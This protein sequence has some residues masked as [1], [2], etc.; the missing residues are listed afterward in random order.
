MQSLLLATI[1]DYEQAINSP[2]AS[3]FKFPSLNDFCTREL[4]DLISKLHQKLSEKVIEG[5]C[6]VSFSIQTKQIGFEMWYF[7]SAIILDRNFVQET[8]LV[9]V[10]NFTR[11]T[12][13]LILKITTEIFPS[14]PR[15]TFVSI[16]EPKTLNTVM[17]FQDD[18]Y[19]VI[20]NCNIFAAINCTQY[21]NLS[22]FFK[23]LFVFAKQINNQINSS[24]Q[25]SLFLKNTGNEK[26]FTKETCSIKKLRFTHPQLS[27]RFIEWCILNYS[28]I[29]HQCQIQNNE[30]IEKMKLVFNQ[31]KPIYDIIN[32]LDNTIY[33]DEY[34]SQLD[35]LI[36]TQIEIT[37]NNE[38]SK[39]L[40]KCFNKAREIWVSLKEE[41]KSFYDC[42]LFFSPSKKRCIKNPLQCSS[43]NWILQNVSKEEIM[44]YY[45]E[46][47]TQTSS[48][49]YWK[50]QINY[51]NLRLY[52][53]KF[54]GIKVH[55]GLLNQQT[56]KDFIKIYDRV[57]K[58]NNSKFII[59]QLFVIRQNAI[60]LL[61]ILKDNE[62]P[63]QR[64]KLVDSSDTDDNNQINDLKHK[65]KEE[66]QCINEESQ[67]IKEEVSA[68]PPQRSIDE[69]VPLFY[70]Q[71]ND[72]SPYSFR[73][74]DEHKEEDDNI[75]EKETQPNNSIE[76]LD[77]DIEE[78]RPK[79]I[80]PRNRFFN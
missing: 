11:I 14:L 40:F 42:V 62:S 46:P 59:S 45:N 72:N 37:H 13:E 49:S 29:I 21:H 74:I 31:V 50:Y 26:I 53:R 3:E 73:Q 36:N 60:E 24:K 70:P 48:L 33:L 68:L 17:K 2:I 64:R 57:I 61:H 47:I 35:N 44:A 51:T 27:F 28:E 56:K 20:D 55:S 34:I 30:L 12:N 39:E 16:H 19:V 63:T 9:N 22:S 52:S 77:L 54:I 65:I 10:S 15:D 41:N 71:E 80:L 7:L 4:N 5:G 69:Q 75:K 32:V 6:E 67:S 23:E 43:L 38:L 1:D 8:Y 58:K 76:N 79:S 25:K 78:Q 66:K 18:K